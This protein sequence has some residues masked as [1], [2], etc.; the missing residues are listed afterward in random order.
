MQGI[1]AH[2]HCT[3]CYPWWFVWLPNLV[4]RR[5]A[6]LFLSFF[7]QFSVFLHDG[8]TN[9]YCI[10]TSYN[11]TLIKIYYYAPRSA[12]CTSLK[13][14]FFLSPLPFTLI[15]NMKLSRPRLNAT[16]IHECTLARIILKLRSAYLHFT[17][18]LVSTSAQPK[19][20]RQQRKL[21]K[22]SLYWAHQKKNNISC[23]FFF[24]QFLF[25]AS[26]LTK[27]LYVATKAIFVL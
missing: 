14:D 15:W 25:S 13:L 5:V 2:K 3:T 8:M 21:S 20:F 11:S 19:S 1:A 23:F 17:Q 18:N 4:T 10:H 22:R 7:R 12:E 9:V 24:S 16:C 6:K 26:M 27:P